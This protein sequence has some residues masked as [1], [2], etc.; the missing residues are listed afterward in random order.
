VA[1]ARPED[2][3]FGIGDAQ[4]RTHLLHQLRGVFVRDD[5][6]R[7]GEV[8]VAADVVVVRVRVDDRHD[9]L[10]GDLLHLLNQRLT[11]AGNLRV[12]EQHPI[13]HDQ[14]ARV[15][16]AEGAWHAANDEE[17]VAQLVDDQ[18]IGGG[19]FR[20]LRGPSLTAA[21]GS[22]LLH[23]SDRCRQRADENDGSKYERA[24]HGVSPNI[25]T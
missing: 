24:F 4:D 1:L 25:R 23:G 22:R 19:W 5:F 8:H 16:A 21:P 14:N 15:A 9:R 7:G 13:R 2:V 3:G 12:D 10:V 11:P 6:D 18:L 20:R 17:V